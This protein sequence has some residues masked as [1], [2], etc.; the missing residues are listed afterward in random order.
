MDRVCSDRMGPDQQLAPAMH[1]VGRRVADR[2]NTITI[3][4][5]PAHQ[6]AE[7]NEAA[8]TWA[9]AAAER[10]FPGDDPA[11]VQETGLSHMTRPAAEARSQT[12]RDWVAKRFRATRRYKPPR[13]RNVRPKLRREYKVLSLGPAGKEDVEGHRESVRLEAPTR[14]LC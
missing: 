2:D 9:K 5:T 13:G 4:W 3:Q 11:F 8:D 12:T 14:S 1:Q 10:L 6:G 7:G